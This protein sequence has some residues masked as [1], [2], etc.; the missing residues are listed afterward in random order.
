MATVEKIKNEIKRLFGNTE[1]PQ[2]Q[3]REDLEDIRDFC[4]ELIETL[5]EED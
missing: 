1:V 3:T 5:P 4:K 2:Q